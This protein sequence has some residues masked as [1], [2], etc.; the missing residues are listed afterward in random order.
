MEG[1]LEKESIM[2]KACIAAL[3]CVAGLVASSARAQSAEEMGRAVFEAHRG[4]VITI[5]CVVKTKFSFQG[6]P[7][8]EDESKIEATATLISPEGLA[9]T[10]LSTVD[11][12]DLYRG[13][14]MG[15]DVQFDANITD[16][17]FLMEGGAE[18][19]AELVL[20]D[21]D[22]D[23]AYFRVRAKPEQPLPHVDLSQ[24]TKAQMLDRVL[25]IN[26]L[27]KV[28]NR[29]HSASFE[30]IEAVVEKPRTFY[31]PGNDPTNTSSGSPAFSL[32]G[33]LV[34]IFVVRALKSSGHDSQNNMLG[35]L[36]PAAEIA[37]GA[38]QVP[39]F[40]TK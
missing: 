15:E 16:A 35:I 27:G 6:R 32:D 14:G 24:S 4:A 8:E 18:L 37:E 2:R 31:I 7:A 1:A 36:L 30:W 19:P 17:K 11:P 5:E 29:V 22:L 9:V 13:M 10:A 25:A 3:A 38:G 23:L 26:R 20:R 40:E 34:G 33:K 39:P 12:S 21:N 28:A